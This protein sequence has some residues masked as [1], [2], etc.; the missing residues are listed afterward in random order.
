VG[1]II[2]LYGKVAIYNILH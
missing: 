2:G 1:F